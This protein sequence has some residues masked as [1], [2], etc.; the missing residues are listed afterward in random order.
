MIDKEA[1]DTIHGILTLALG[2]DWSGKLIGIPPG[3]DP[4]VVERAIG[5]LDDLRRRDD[6]RLTVTRNGVTVDLPGWVP[7]PVIEAFVAMADSIGVYRCSHTELADYV[8]SMAEMI[9]RMS[10]LIGA[11]DPNFDGLVTVDAINAALSSLRETSAA[12]DGEKVVA[13]H[14]SAKHV[15]TVHNIVHATTVFTRV[16]DD[17]IG[18]SELSVMSLGETMTLPGESS[19]VRTSEGWELWQA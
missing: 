8:E 10:D 5:Q 11:F 1:A 17:T 4:D 12:N 18:T 7:Y 13:L 19:I 16:T 2:R 6:D 14:R 3:F 15:C 9:R